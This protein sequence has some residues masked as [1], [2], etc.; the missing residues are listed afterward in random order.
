MFNAQRRSGMR[1]ASVALIVTAIGFAL[2]RA[3]AQEMPVEAV[4]KLYQEAIA[5][6]EKKDYAAYLERI[7]T[8]A[9]QRPAHPVLLR[10]LASAYALNARPADAARVLGQM[11]SLSIYHNTTD[12]P[13]FTAVRGD[14][15]VQLAVRALDVLTSNDDC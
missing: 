2:V 5:A 9:Q 6:Y 13:D 8:V 10:R 1:R 14:P 4:R 15:S 11:A 7:E 3:A 12:D